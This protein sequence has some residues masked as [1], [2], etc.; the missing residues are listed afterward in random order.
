[1][2]RS[3]SQSDPGIVHLQVNGTDVCQ[4]HQLPVTG[5]WQT[6]LS[7]TVGQVIIPGGTSKVRFYFDKAGSNVSF[8]RFL[9]PVPVSTVP[10]GFISGATNVTGNII[11]IT[12]N[13][14]IT[15][16]TAPSTDFM[17]KADGNAI[18]ITAVL[19]QPG[20]NRQLI[21]QLDG[22]ITFGQ[23][24]TVSYSGN[25]IFSD[26]QVLGGFTDQ[27]VKNNLPRRNIL[28][29]KIQSEDFNFNSGFGF[30]N[31]T[32]SGGGQNMCCANDGDYLDYFIEVPD[33]A[34]YTLSIRYASLVSTGVVS[35]R[36]GSENAFT[37][38]RNIYFSATGGWQSWTTKILSIPLPKGS[39]T[40]R[41]YS[42]AGEYNLNWFEFSLPADVNEV[43]GLKRFNIYPNP[44][45]GCF[46]VEAEF[47]KRTSVEL[48]LYDLLGKRMVSYLIDN[49]I[50]LERQIDDRPFEP[51]IYLMCLS[52]GEGMLSRKVI[53]N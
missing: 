19:T 14:P 50:V 31:C 2:F 38:I 46:T 20:N 4:P 49:T 28:P 29:A 44:S 30:E 15:S 48:S 33:S 37:S 6:W 24:V 32:D 18:G 42:V 16:L 35:L 34:E 27:P 45:E 3:A 1:M 5:G 11:I 36:L 53:I 51:G 43:P 40:L 47:S 25:A 9:D 12:L 22:T 41:F 23:E 21:L 17:V 26:S 13:K 10:F 39:Y 8:F 52:T 7:S